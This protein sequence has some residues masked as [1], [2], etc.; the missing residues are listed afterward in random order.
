MVK[1]TNH[2][3]TNTKP[4]ARKRWTASALASGDKLVGFTDRQPRRKSY[5]HE[6]DFRE[7]RH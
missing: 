4:S 3:N 6:K 7:H 1:K 2:N 5:T